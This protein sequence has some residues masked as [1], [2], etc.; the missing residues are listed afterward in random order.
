[1]NKLPKAPTVTGKNSD[2]R[3]GR[4]GVEGSLWLAHRV[5]LA[6]VCT[7]KTRTCGSLAILSEH[8]RPA[9]P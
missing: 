5:F 3:G 2:G 4:L 9:S 8:T 1:M 7:T 6:E